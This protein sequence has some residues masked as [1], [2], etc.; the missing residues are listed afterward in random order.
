MKFTASYTGS[1]S[2]EDDASPREKSQKSQKG[3]TDFCVK[4]ISQHAFG[5]REI[6]IAEQGQLHPC[7]S[8]WFIAA[9]NYIYF[10]IFI[11]MLKKIIVIFFLWCLEYIE[12]TLILWSNLNILL[13]FQRCQELWHYVRGLQ[14]ISLWREPRLL[15]V[16]ISMHKQL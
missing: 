9:N 6:E 11:F 12:M 15:V 1:S 14:M 8:Q 13:L 4:N 2:D 5:R 7:S 16:L 3:F 10:Q